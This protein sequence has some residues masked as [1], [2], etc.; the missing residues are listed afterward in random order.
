LCYVTI[1]LTLKT[2]NVVQSMGYLL[3]R[4]TS[5]YNVLALASVLAISCV[6]IG[7][8]PGSSPEN[9]YTAPQPTNV[10]PAEF[11]RISEVWTLLEQQH[12]NRDELDPEK[13][14]EA[15]IRGMLGALDDPYASFLDAEQFSMESEDVHGSFEG[16]GAHVGMRDNLITIIAPMPDS[17]AEKAGI[18][19]GDVILGING[20]TTENTTLLEAVSKIR[21]KRGTTVDLLILHLGYSDPENIT[22][23]RGVIQ[24]DSIHFEIMPDDVGYLHISSFTESTKSEVQKALKEFKTSTESG[25][26]IIDLRNNPGGLLTSVVDVAS[27]FLDSGMVLYEIDGYQAR[28]DWKVKHNWGQQDYPI[29][30]I[31]NQFSAS[32]SEVL[33][34]ALMDHD[35]ATVIGTTSF[36]KGSVNILRSLSDGSGI[37]FSVAHW[38]TPEGTLIEGSGITPDVIVDLP[39][40]S[41]SDV[42]LEKALGILKQKRAEFG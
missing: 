26:L 35:R 10:L 13:L 22:V 2:R 11:N 7:C 42:Q 9:T 31:M 25:G 41:Q 39:K 1:N 24:L 21:G 16:I 5:H 14:S 19:P 15:A 33:C 12:I 23:K 18:L 32:A 37:Y 36:G 8:V 30:V 17:P 4:K 38:F 34:G 40:D 27:L 29:V 6:I 3:I 28:K 20:A